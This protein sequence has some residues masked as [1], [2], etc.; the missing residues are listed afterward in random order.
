[1]ARSR[2]SKL[3]IHY[4]S[5]GD[6]PPLVMLRGLARNSKHWLGFDREVAKHFR[7]LTI[8]ARGLGQTP[9][10]MGALDSVYDLADDVIRVLDAENIE[11]AHILGVSLGGMVTMAAGLQ[12]PG[13][14]SSLIV[15]NSS[16]AGTPHRRLSREAIL[17]LLRA[18]ITGPAAYEELARILLG[19]EA[20]ATVRSRV[21]RDWLKIDQSMRASPAVVIKQLIAA[22]RF[23]VAEDLGRISRPTLVLYGTGD[24]FVPC[25]NSRTIADLIPGS[26]LVGIPGGG[27][28]LTLDCPAEVLGEIL[29]FTGTHSK[30]RQPSRTKV[31]K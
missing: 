24:Q 17:V 30:A 31:K 16:F 10:S 20:S 15:I 25:A 7:V 29:K 9:L 28:E 26:Q 18:V 27:H 12:H 3:D 4:E 8:D 6:G 23:R 2:K 19:P 14:A 22:A 21:A 13:R 1:M 5:K 11:Q